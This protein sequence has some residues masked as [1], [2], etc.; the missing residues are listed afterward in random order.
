MS[1]LKISKKVINQ[2]VNG[3]SL[4]QVKSKAAAS[5]VRLA[6]PGDIV[7]SQVYGGGGN[8]G[9]VYKNDFI[10]LFNRSGSSIDIT[11]WSVQYAAAAGTSWQTTTLTGTI[12]AGGYFLI[13]QAAGTGGTTNL[14]TA[15]ATGNIPM[16]GTA[17]KVALVSNNTALTISCP[18]GVA[19]VI[20]FVGFGST[21]NCSEGAGPTPAPSATNAV[22]RADN[23]CTDANNNASDFTT[24]A[25]NPRN[26]SSPV[27]VC[28][29]LSPSI[30]VTPSPVALTYNLGSGPLSQTVTVNAS[31]LNP[32]AGNVTVTSSNTAVTLSNGGNFGSSVTLPY[33]N[34]GL[35]ST[36]LVAQLTSGLSAGTYST[37]LVFAGGG[38]TF[39]LPV[40]GTVVDNGAVTLIRSIQ[41]TTHISPLNGQAVNNV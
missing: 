41:G 2:S 40:N 12:P 21:A 28:G 17:G 13:Q 38:A 1:S 33:T 7:I 5:K 34:A 14:P 37:T 6:N 35:T 30:S 31:N 15:D 22:F 25:A 10:E 29:T 20:D 26:S 32:A 3:I 19:G 27:S 36:T 9:S 16:S 4:N 24:G 11:G 8:S 18:V 39:N 23:G